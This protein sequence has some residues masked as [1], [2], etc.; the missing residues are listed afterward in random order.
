MVGIGTMVQQTN[1]LGRGDPEASSLASTTQ[2]SSQV[3]RVLKN[4]RVVAAVKGRTRIDVLAND[5]GVLTADAS[6]LEI[7]SLPKCGRA[8]VADGA[9]HYL[10]D[11]TCDGIQRFHYGLTDAPG[12]AEVVLTVHQDVA[13]VVA[14][15]VA[16]KI[17]EPTGT[18]SPREVAE[19]TLAQR[20]EAALAEKAGYAAAVAA[21]LESN[22]EAVPTIEDAPALEIATAPVLEIGTAPA[23]EIAAAP[24][25]YVDFAVSSASESII[26]AALEPAILSMPAPET[27]PLRIS[28]VEIAE[29]IPVVTGVPT[30][31]ASTSLMPT[32]SVSDDTWAGDSLSQTASLDPAP[33][34]LPQSATAIV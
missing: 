18:T 6:L 13:D 11:P 16:S 33:R 28:P 4:D 21:A 2:S 22:A 20:I 32:G 19:M 9:V 5:E 29:V 15:A 10:P 25:P 3:L 1:L 31:A 12:F 17:T 27:A 7:V 26:V 8:L 14:M 24:A 34:D 23:L 30:D